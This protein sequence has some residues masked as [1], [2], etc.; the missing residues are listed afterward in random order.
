MEDGQLLCQ[1]LNLYEQ[2][3]ST[4]VSQLFVNWGKMEAFT[5]GQW[6]RGA[7]PDYQM[8]C[9]GAEKCL[10]VE[11]GT[12]E[13]QE[14]NWEDIVGK[15]RGKLSEWTWVLQGRVLVAS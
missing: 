8:V 15:V 9:S 7:H 12:K 14:K 3:S 10:G 2:A 4:K 13:Y 6:H 5:M 1:I 11:L